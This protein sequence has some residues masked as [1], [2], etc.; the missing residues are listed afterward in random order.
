MMKRILKFVFL[1]L[2]ICGIALSILNFMT[3]DSMASSDPVTISPAVGTFTVDGE[4]YGR[5]LNC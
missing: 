2:I 4:C 5:P 3:A 1:V